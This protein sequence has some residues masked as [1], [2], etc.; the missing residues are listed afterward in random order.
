[1]AF[2]LMFSVPRGNPCKRGGNC[3]PHCSLLSAT[4]LPC[5]P[6][7]SPSALSVIIPFSPGEGGFQPCSMSGKFGLIKKFW[8]P[9]QSRFPS[10]WTLCCIFCTPCTLCNF[11]RIQKIKCECQKINIYCFVFDHISSKDA[12]SAKSAWCALC[13]ARHVS[14]SPLHNINLYNIN[15]LITMLIS[16]LKYWFHWLETAKFSWLTSWAA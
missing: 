3:S 11:S 7:C 5:S 2:L 13:A 15:I 9:N 6:L 14:A 12:R 10:V 8:S 16:R 1:M 4:S